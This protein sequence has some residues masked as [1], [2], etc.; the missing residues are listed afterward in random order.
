[1]AICRHNDWKV[2]GDGCYKECTVCGVWLG[3]RTDPHNYDGDYYHRNNTI[4]DGIP[5]RQWYWGIHKA[6][7][8]QMG[9][10]FTAMERV[11]E[12]GCGTGQLLW[13]LY[14]K[15]GIRCLGVE[16]SFWAYNWQREVHG[17]DD[18]YQILNF[19]VEELD[20]SILIEVPEHE[21][22]KFNFIYSCHVMEHLIDPM[23]MI[24]RSHEMLN[25]GGT[26]YMAVP[27]KEHQKSLHVHK[28]TYD[29]ECIRMWFEQAG[30]KNIQI[31]QTKPHNPPPVNGEYRGHYLHASGVK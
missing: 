2:R 13:S 3:N 25:S 23:R 21:D 12:Y 8:D 4:V 5:Q 20:N 30:F 1:M 22:R 7:W 6:I 9:I 14:R 15:Y 18:D 24:E 26:F 28:W 29:E 16:Q 17:F 27:D 11:L 19:N 10:D 31:I